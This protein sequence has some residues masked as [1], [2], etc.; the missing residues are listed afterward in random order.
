MMLR[1]SH[2]MMENKQWVSSRFGFQNVYNEYF[3]CNND[4]KHNFRRMIVA[5]ATKEFV[6]FF[7]QADNGNADVTKDDHIRV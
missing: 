5:Q 4:T 6:F 3:Q 7:S 2:V 1:P